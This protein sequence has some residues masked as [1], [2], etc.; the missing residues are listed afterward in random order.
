VPEEKKTLVQAIAAYH[1][2]KPPP[3][4]INFDKCPIRSHQLD[5]TL[6]FRCNCTSQP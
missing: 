6:N 5:K 4:D 3:Y 2:H 1:H